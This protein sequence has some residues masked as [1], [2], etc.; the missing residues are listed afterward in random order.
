[1][2]CEYAH[3]VLLKYEGNFLKFEFCSIHLSFVVFVVF[4]IFVVFYTIN[5]N[6]EKVKKSYFATQLA[7]HTSY[8]TAVSVRCYFIIVAGCTMGVK[9]FKIVVSY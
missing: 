1:V 4:V 7:H 3:F 5:L 8:Y 2:K 9:L 6:C